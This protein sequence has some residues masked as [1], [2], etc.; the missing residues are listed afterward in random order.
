MG[1]YIV[2]VLSVV[3][4]GGGLWPNGAAYGVLMRYADG[5][6]SWLPGYQTAFKTIQPF[7]SKTANKRQ[8]RENDKYNHGR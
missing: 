6:I 3:C 5:Y 7:S 8:N 2:T 1:R 4:D